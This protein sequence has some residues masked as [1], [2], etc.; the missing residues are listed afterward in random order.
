[1]NRNE[2]IKDD[3]ADTDDLKNKCFCDY[4]DAFV[5]TSECTAID[6][7]D[8]FEVACSEC[9]INLYKDYFKEM[10]RIINDNE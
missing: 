4:C 7:N 3:E 8:S 5:P 1:M 2:I 10:E 6:V 9:Y